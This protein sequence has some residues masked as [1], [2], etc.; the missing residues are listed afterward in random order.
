MRET[1]LAVNAIVAAVMFGLA[2]SVA[3][4]VAVVA[5]PLLV[6]AALGWII[7]RARGHQS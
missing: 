2:I 7:G 6:L 1:D 4:I 5:A 3:V